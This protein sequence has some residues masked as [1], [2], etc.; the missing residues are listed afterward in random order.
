MN[1]TFSHFSPAPSFALLCR[2]WTAVAT[3]ALVLVL[4]GCR[5]QQPT[6]PA[7][8]VNKEVVLYNWEGDLPPSVLETFTREYGI[9]VRY[10]TFTSQEEAVTELRK[11]RI[12]DVVVLENPF[13]PELIAEAR[14]LELSRQ[15]MPNL[16]N[17]SANFRDLAVDPGNRYTAPYHY[18]TTGLLVR[19][20]LVDRPVTHWADLWRPELRGKIALRLQPREL[21]SLALL[22]LGFDL[23]SAQ[24]SEVQAAVDQLIALKPWILDVEVDSTKAAAPLLDGRVQVLVGWPLDYQATHGIHAA[25]DYILPKE[26]LP[27]WSDNYVIPANCRNRTGAEQLIDFL[28]RADISAQI[29]RERNYPTANEAAL[30]LIPQELRNDPVVFPPTEAL[31]RAHFYLPQTPG[32]QQLYRQAWTRFLHAAPA[33]EV[34]R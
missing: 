32:T 9:Q 27:L 11:G 5:E 17:I 26:G 15:T 10:E 34:E 21:I 33:S 24:P 23:N 25:V 22:S 16:R 3:L 30:A 19:T 18:G 28:L 14:L 31:R 7:S 8:A 1:H 13:I 12:V 29:V 6:A 20:D 2:L 4:S